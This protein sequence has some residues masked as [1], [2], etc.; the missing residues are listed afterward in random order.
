VSLHGDPEPAV[1]KAGEQAT[2]E[3]H[4]VPIG[5]AIGGIGLVVVLVL[6]F[7]VVN[8]H[9]VHKRELPALIAR[10]RRIPPSCPPSRYASE[11]AISTRRTGASSTRIR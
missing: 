3:R 10:G 2:R 5:A 8:D 1:Q 11:F 4:S 7:V 6:L 9:V